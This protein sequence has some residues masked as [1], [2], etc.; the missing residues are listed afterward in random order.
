IVLACGKGHEQSMCFGGRE[1]L[2][3][4]RTA[5]RAAL[6]ELLGVVGLAMPYLPTQNTPEE[7]WLTW[8]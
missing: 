2:W 5:V 4:D 8:R 7:E 1:H 6:S 3:D